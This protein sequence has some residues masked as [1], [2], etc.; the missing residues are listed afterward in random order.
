MFYRRTPHHFCN[1]S[2]AGY[3]VS[4][5]K[6]ALIFIVLVASLVGFADATYLAV[7]HYREAP[8]VCEIGGTPFGSCEGVLDSPYATVLGIPMSLV[9]AFYYFIVFLLASGFSRT[10]D[11]RLMRALAVIAGLGFVTTLW[12]V[13]LQLFVL[14]AL[15]F[16]CVVSA[17]ATTLLFASSLTLF[18][19]ARKA[20]VSLPRG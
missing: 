14:H 4:A 20:A 18:V 9:G 13:Y 19:R 6:S 11:I 8:V 1:K 2:G 12:F 5:V 10:G 3:T 17:L 7:Q 16:Y 15:C